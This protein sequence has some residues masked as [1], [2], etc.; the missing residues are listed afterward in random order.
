MQWEPIRKSPDACRVRPHLLDYGMT[1]AGF[2]WENVRR[3][4]AGL[5]GGQGLNIA[6]EAVDRHLGGPLQD[7]LAMRWL[8]KE[9]AVRDLTFADLSR[10]SSRFANVLRK[11]GVGK[12]ERVFVLAAVV[13][14]IASGWYALQ[15]LPI[16][17]FPDVSDTQVN[18]ITLYPGRAPEE[19][20]KQVTIPLEISLAGVP[21]LGSSSETQPAE[22]NP[23]RF[24]PL[25]KL[26]V[27]LPTIWPSSSQTKPVM[28]SGKTGA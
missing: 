16:E 9:G 23:T 6:H 8:G 21:P 1:C 15:N 14:L 20:E 11:F 22:F 10:E 24:S 19:V 2:S 3:E 13:V 12:G 28:F 25:P 4:L 18:V 27:T 5:P 17:A 7:R 26:I